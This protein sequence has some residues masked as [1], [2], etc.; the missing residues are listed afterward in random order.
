MD[1]LHAAAHAPPLPR[2][3]KIQFN[4]TSLQTRSGIELNNITPALSMLHYAD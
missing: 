4:K 1:K 2:K 3:T